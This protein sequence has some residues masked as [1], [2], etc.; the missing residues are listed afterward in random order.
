MESGAG[1]EGLKSY[2]GKWQGRLLLACGKCQRKIRRSGKSEGLG[3]LRKSLKQLGKAHD[4][5]VRLKVIQTD[6]LKVCP[7][8]GVVVCTQTDFVRGQFSILRD[9]EDVAGIYRKCTG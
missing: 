3:K 7:K 6:C 1:P 5:A 9:D 4:S 2:T 8:G